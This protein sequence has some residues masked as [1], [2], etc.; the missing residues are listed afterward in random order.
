MNY[1]SD[2]DF[3]GIYRYISRK[4][5]ETCLFIISSPLYNYDSMSMRLFNS[6]RSKLEHQWRQKISNKKQILSAEKRI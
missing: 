5:W 6:T 2:A 4:M 3:S 1:L